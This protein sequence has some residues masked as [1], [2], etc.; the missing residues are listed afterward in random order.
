MIESAKQ[1]KQELQIDI[2]HDDE[3][4][5][6]AQASPDRVVSAYADWSTKQ[7]IT[8]FWRLYLVGFAVSVSGMYLG[9]TLSLPGSI[10]ANRGRRAAAR[11]G[12]EADSQALSP[13]LVPSLLMVNWPSTHNTLDFGTLSTSCRKSSFR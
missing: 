12:N 13:S 11:V 6:G 3:A 2:K 1:D 9:F 8:T 10:V 4:E 5:L 7:T